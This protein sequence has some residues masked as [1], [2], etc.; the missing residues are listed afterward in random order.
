MMLG[1]LAG[2]YFKFNPIW[3]E[4]DFSPLLVTAVTTVAALLF[5]QS[6][7]LFGRYASCR[8]E[9][10][11]MVAFSVLIAIVI[12]AVSQIFDSWQQGVSRALL[13]PIVHLI[14]FTRFRAREESYI[15][16]IKE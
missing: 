14:F 5:I 15:N 10:N 9:M 3:P 4:Q 13:L 1:V 11:A 6:Y 8:E 12:V 7:M 16:C 2:G